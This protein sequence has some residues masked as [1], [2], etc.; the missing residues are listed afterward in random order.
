MID[1]NDIFSGLESLK[2]E[3]IERHVITK[4]HEAKYK[5]WEIAELTGLSGRSIVRKLQ[6]FN[7]ANKSEAYNKYPQK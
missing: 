2:M 4:L 7:L 5:S 3:D 6:L 1:K